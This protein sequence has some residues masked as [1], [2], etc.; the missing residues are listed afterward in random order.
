MAVKVKD[1]D[2]IIVW[3]SRDPEPDIRYTAG[4]EDGPGRT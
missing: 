1:A 3:L 4:R 2:P